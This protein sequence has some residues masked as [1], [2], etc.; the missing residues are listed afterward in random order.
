MAQQGI[1]FDLE[2]MALVVGGVVLV[3][4]GLY[5]LLEIRERFRY[6]EEAIPAAATLD[7]YRD[8]RDQGLLDETE[9]ERVRLLLDTP[10]CRVGKIPGGQPAPR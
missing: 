3:A 10:F 2:F 7:H 1:A 5:A 6:R 4:L 9:F 8:L